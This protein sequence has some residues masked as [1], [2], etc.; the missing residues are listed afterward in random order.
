MGIIIG[1]VAGGLILLATI[2]VLFFLS[3]RRRHSPPKIE[4]AGASGGK[5]QRMSGVSSTPTASEAD[6]QAVSEVDG[7]AAR[8]WSMRS[9]LEGSAVFSNS[10][11]Y[12]G[13]G[14]A[15]D[16][17]NG[18]HMWKGDELSPV[19]ELPAIESWSGGG[20]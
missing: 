8:P 16:G 11:N 7:R 18:G 20:R 9:E 5:P 1:A 10:P 15:M 14:T 6:G 2:A 17:P 4:T 12:A 19:A 13:A 3:R